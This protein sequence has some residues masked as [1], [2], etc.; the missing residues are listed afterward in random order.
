LSEVAGCVA[1]CEPGKVVTSADT[2][3]RPRSVPDERA[4]RAQNR[5]R[6]LD[7]AGG[8]LACAESLPCKRPRRS[9]SARRPRQSPAHPLKTG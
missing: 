7:D 8:P 5:G 6:H 2:A 9:N 4:V 3:R 1:A